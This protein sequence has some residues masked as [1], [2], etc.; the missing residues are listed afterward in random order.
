M[1]KHKL[2]L[3][4][5]KTPL[6]VGSGDANFDLV[7]RQIQRDPLTE[8]PTIH[9]S[10]LKGALKEYCKFRHNEEEAP[11]FLAH[12]FGDDDNSGK[13][14]F[15]QAYLL[16]V[17]MRANENPYYHVTSPKAIEELLE[18][19]E[20]FSLSLPNK[21]ALQQIAK[22]NGQDVLVA[23]KDTVIEDWEAKHSDDFDFKALEELI[24]APAA[25]VPN[26][27][28]SEMLKDLPVIARNQ[29]EN[30]ESKNLWYEEV[31]PRKSKLFTLISEPTYLNDNDAKKL[32]NAF[33][34]F[35]NY[36]TDE[37]TIHIGA[38]A[39]IGYGVTTF[40]ELCHA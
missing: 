14:R 31:L 30:G 8:Y 34:R 4:E 23:T 22:Y 1:F 3:I 21:E 10:S 11:N 36:L 6:H 13:V 26:E 16:S 29:L 40:K 27:I 35:S 32:Q 33:E 5:N 18:V 28:F 9:A 24:G 37:N 15:T 17:P 25:I 38:N 2:Y 20:T 12:I 19:V 39:S 7:D